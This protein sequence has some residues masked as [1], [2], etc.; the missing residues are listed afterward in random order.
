VVSSSGAG[1]K[2]TVQGCLERLYGLHRLREQESAL[3]RGEGGHGENPGSPPAR[4]RPAA[5]VRVRPA[6]RPPPIQ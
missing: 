2:G 1:G 6:S 4:K 3:Q 5:S